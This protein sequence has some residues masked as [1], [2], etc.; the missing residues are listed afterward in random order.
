MKS[1]VIVINRFARFILISIAIIMLSGCGLRERLLSPPD[2]FTLPE[3][4]L[5][6]ECIKDENI[7]RF[8]YQNDGVYQYF[9]NEIEQ[10]EDSVD[11]LIEQAYLNGSSV[12]NYLAIEYPDSCTFSKY[13]EN[14]D[15]K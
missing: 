1:E 10:D 11:Y 8:I 6:A 4:S 7:Y 14:D 9:I 15:K 2:E 3:G 5:V 12:E 13:E